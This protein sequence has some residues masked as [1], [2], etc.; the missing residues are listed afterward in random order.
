MGS[1]AYSEKSE[2]RILNE[3]DDSYDLIVIGGTPAGLSLAAEAQ[4]SGLQRVLVLERS[5]TIRPS[6]GAGRLSL[7]VRFQVEVVLIE[8]VD[9]GVQVLTETGTIICLTATVDTSRV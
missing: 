8:P 1:V 7:R 9:A 4:A 6:D 2:G 5:D 3:V